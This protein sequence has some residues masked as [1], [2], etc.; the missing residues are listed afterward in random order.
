MDKH[1]IESIIKDFI[2]TSPENSLHMATGEPA[3]EEAIIGCS[4]GNDPI[5]DSYKTYVG[6]FH[7]T[8]AEIFNLTFPD[9]PG[10]P[11]DLSVISWALIQREAVK[12]ENRKENFYPSER[13]V[14]A[15]FP[16]ERFNEILRRHVVDE[17]G[18]PGIKAVAP[19]LSPHWKF[20]MSEKYFLS[21]R[22]SERH[23]AYASGLGTFGL[24]DG[25]ITKRGKAHRVGSVVARVRLAPTPRPYTDHHEYCL[26]YAT[27]KCMACAERCPV[28]AISEKGHDKQ[29]CMEHTAGTCGKYVK[30]KWN[31]DGY[32]CGLCQT[33]VPCESGIPKG[34]PR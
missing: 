29:K 3:W 10:K 6:Q 30:E 33:K 25:L 28:G 5:Y 2:R 13:W 18:R 31:F 9:D 14:M 12:A 27:G 20:E 19:T 26:Y 34:I 1:V 21:S 11:E 17:L 32:G 8:P 7:Y 15:R 23:A 16:G 4:A 24:C 22:W